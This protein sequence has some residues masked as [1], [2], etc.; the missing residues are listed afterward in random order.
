MTRARTWAWACF[1]AVGI[2]VVVASAM[3]P[4]A[5]GRT[6]AWVAGGLMG[7]AAM[8]LAPR[9]HRAPHGWLWRTLAVAL[10][11]W[12]TSGALDAALGASSDLRPW[13]PDAASLIA[14][15]VVCVAL[16]GFIRA[17][18][19]SAGARD[20]GRCDPDGG[21]ADGLLDLR[22]LSR[23]VGRDGVGTL[24]RRGAPTVLRRPGRGL[25]TARQLPGPGPG[26]VPGRRDDDRRG[27][28]V[29]GGRPRLGLAYLDNRP[30]ATTQFWLIT[31]V[32]AGAAAL[33]PS[34]RT[35]TEPNRPARSTRTGSRCSG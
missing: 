9:L 2:P 17:A 22:R 15:A 5:T 26:R 13:L 34:L 12:V 1:L 8:A 3:L 27:A 11:L 20:L 7:S 32:L 29:P 16:L 35:L 6:V 23:L 33:H 14:V 10:T 21:G 30:T 31:F 24:V 18:R 19:E 4:S 25:R 28:A